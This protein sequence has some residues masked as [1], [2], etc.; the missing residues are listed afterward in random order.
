MGKLK[1]A[2]VGE[3]NLFLP[4]DKELDITFKNLKEHDSNV[5]LL[6]P[7][8]EYYNAYLILMRD[9][10]LDAQVL[11][12]NIPLLL[13]DWDYLDVDTEKTFEVEMLI[14][15]KIDISVLYVPLYNFKFEGFQ[16]VDCTFD[17]YTNNIESIPD[18]RLKE[19]N[20]HSKVYEN[21]KLEVEYFVSDAKKLA[22][23]YGYDSSR[24]YPEGNL[25]KH[26]LFFKNTEST[27]GSEIRFAHLEHEPFVTSCKELLENVVSSIQFKKKNAM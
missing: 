22:E 15:D 8:E 2:H 6:K 7:S 25:L 27:F 4:I 24:K 17:E 19:Q 9:I 14:R 12:F 21:R 10:N 1:N 18:F 20:E 16:I 3:V 23:L 13:N 5:Y 26:Q 11:H